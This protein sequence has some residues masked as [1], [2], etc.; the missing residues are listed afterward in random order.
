MLLGMLFLSIFSSAAM[1]APADYLPED[2]NL[3]GY[4]LVW[5]ALFENEN[6][7]YED[8]EN[9]TVGAQIWAQNDTNDNVLAIVG[10]VVVQVGENPLLQEIPSDA[11]T[12]LENLPAT[13]A[14]MDDVT[15][16][17][18]LF[19]EFMTDTSEHITD[20]TGQIG[21]TTG[22]LAFNN[23]AEG[24]MIMSVDPGVVI[25]TFAFTIS[26]Q[27]FQMIQ[28]GSNDLEGIFQGMLNAF[29]ALVS[30]LT[31]II[32]ALSQTP[33]TSQLGLESSAAEQPT[34]DETD[35]SDVQAVTSG[36][37]SVYSKGIPGYTPLILL[38]LLGGLGLYFV[39]FK[40][41]KIN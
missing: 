5:E 41:L 12:F 2:E 37:G 1:A 9:L 8:G 27:W 29:Q 14:Y 30:A 35:E 6:P 4:D 20:V 3:E 13:S 10:S 24:Y 34:G 31:S 33:W 38:T 28:Q 19:V 36:I 15:T 32:N 17:W 21:T 7:L 26:E 22:S 18:D 16:W 23:S 25:W 40:N 11:R 39:N